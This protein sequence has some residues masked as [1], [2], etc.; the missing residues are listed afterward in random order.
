MD[1]HGMVH[2]THRCSSIGSRLIHS[3]EIVL[4]G[5]QYMFVVIT[6]LSGRS[7]WE[8]NV[9]MYPIIDHLAAQTS[10][11]GKSR[12]KDN[13]GNARWENAVPTWE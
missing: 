10:P 13:D 3:T 4:L 7:D 6:L 12:Q 2:R 1:I 8:D 11:K 5:M 9:Y